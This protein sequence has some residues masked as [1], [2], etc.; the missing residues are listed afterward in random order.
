[1][2]RVLLGT[3]IFSLL[4]FFLFVM[5]MNYSTIKLPFAD[6]TTKASEKINHFYSEE[7]LSRLEKLETVNDLNK[8]FEIEC[9]RDP[10]VYSSSYLPY[11]VF[12][13]ENGK[14]YYVFFEPN[15][16][17]DYDN[18]RIQLCI[19]NE[20][21]LSDDDLLQQIECLAEKGSDWLGWVELLEK[22]ESGSSSG[23][24]I[25]SFILASQNGIYC[26]SLSKTET[27]TYFIKDLYFY[28]DDTLINHPSEIEKNGWFPWLILPIDKE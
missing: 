15:N 1:M 24:R 17:H 12:Q 21:F 3:S 8:Y 13:S 9:V 10:R 16:I 27:S 28:S 25:R 4:L 18:G 5:T 11:V 19:V 7:D 2:K 20:R 26:I 6:N 22:Y 23:A 14:R